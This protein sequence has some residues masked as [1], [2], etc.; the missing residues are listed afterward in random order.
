VQTATNLVVKWPSKQSAKEPWCVPTTC[1]RGCSFEGQEPWFT[2]PICPFGQRVG[3]ERTIAVLMENAVRIAWDY[4]ERS[5]ELDDP[6]VA[7][8]VLLSFIEGMI[9]RGETRTLMLSNRAIDAYR[10]FKA[11]QQLARVS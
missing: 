10:K 9:R 6:E 11:A 8:L 1:Y 3:H 7:S 5:G 2:D 4:L